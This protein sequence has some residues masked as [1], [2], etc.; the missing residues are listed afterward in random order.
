[1][2][3]VFRP[4]YGMFAY[5][6]ETRTYWFNSS[7]LEANSEFQL[8]GILLG[9]ALYN[10]VILDVHLPQVGPPPKSSK[11]HLQGGPVIY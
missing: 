11:A 1:V 2:I 3:E 7:S 9:L 4:E 6:E 8:V 5:S 10:G